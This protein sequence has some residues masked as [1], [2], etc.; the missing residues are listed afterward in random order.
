MIYFNEKIPHWNGLKIN[1][2]TIFILLLL[3]LINML[4]LPEWISIFRP[5]L[6][7]MGYI[8]FL[9]IDIPK[10][11]FIFA[12]VFGLL[13]DVLFNYPLGINPILLILLSY[14]V[15]LINRQL[16]YYPIWQQSL[17][18][19]IIVLL[20][21]AVLSIIKYFLWSSFMLITI[22][23]NFVMAFICWPWL[24]YWLDCKYINVV[25]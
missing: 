15:S 12:I 4:P 18:V 22:P 21:Y 14:G 8:Y 9:I 16:L 3:L 7:I 17:Y 13:L 24:F 11:K 20:Y 25:S 10:A 23:S 19:G 1:I 5:D 2:K 6:F